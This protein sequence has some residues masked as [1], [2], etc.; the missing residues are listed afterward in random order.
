MKF[1]TLRNYLCLLFGRD[2]VNRRSFVVSWKLE[3]VINENKVLSC[4]NYRELGRP[5]NVFIKSISKSVR[6]ALVQTSSLASCKDDILKEL[7]GRSS[8]W[9]VFTLRVVAWDKTWQMAETTEEDI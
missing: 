6:L 1:I 7:K 3:L 9:K 5:L 2:F 8:L 4:W